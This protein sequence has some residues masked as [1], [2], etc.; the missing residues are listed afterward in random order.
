MW[1][2]F[3]FATLGVAKAPK[4]PD[5]RISHMVEECVRL[6]KAFSE[7]KWPIFA[8]LDCHHPD[9]PEPPYPPHC[10]IGSNEEKL[11][12]G[13]FISFRRVL[14]LYYRPIVMANFT[15]IVIALKVMYD[16]LY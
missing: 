3:G 1:R 14:L 13:N 5:Q 9:K 6:S 10:I 15:Y 7:R 4:Q 11:V 2:N 8:F 16:S 12:P